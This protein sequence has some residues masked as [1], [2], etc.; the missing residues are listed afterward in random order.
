MLKI[1]DKIVYIVSLIAAFGLIGAYLSPI[2]NPN[3]FVF[4]S[5]LGLAYPYLLIGNFILLLYWI[6][7]WKRRAWQIVVVIAIGYPTFRTYYGTAKTETG[8]VS[9]DLSLLSYNIRYFDV[10]GWSNQKNTRVNGN[11]DRRKTVIEQLHTYPY[12]YIEKDMAIFSRLPILH[13]GHLTFAPGYSSSCIYGDFKL[14]KD[15]VRLYSVH[16]ESYKLGKKE[17]QFMK[18]ISSGLKG[19]D[20]PEGVK[21]LTTR[22]MIANKNRAHQAEEIQRHIDGSPYP[23]ILCGDFND[24]PLSYTYRQLSRKLTDS[25]IEKGR[26][27]GN[28][29]IG[30]FPSFRIDYVLHSPTL[31]TVG[32][33]REDIT[34]SD[35]YPIKV[36]IRKGS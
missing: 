30:E 8:D 23:V 20:I 29:Y 33:T 21:N 16:L 27:I 25:F 14:G 26:G 17:R 22:L 15:T 1:L 19:N 18:E 34:L 13:K 24:T 35:H 6:F 12:Y 4:F 10:Y 31:Y 11:P 32:Y 7:R 36:K 28:T 3:T 5:L 9:Y 2:I